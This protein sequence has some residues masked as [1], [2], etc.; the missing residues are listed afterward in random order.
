MCCVI[1]KIKNA[2]PKNA[3][4]HSGLSVLYQPTDRQIMKPGIIVTCAGSIM[5]ESSTTSATPRPGQCSRANAYATKVLENRVPS[6]VS[7]TSSML[8]PTYRQNGTE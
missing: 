5:V 2:D 8:L 6:V 4:A 7:A 3:G 1:R